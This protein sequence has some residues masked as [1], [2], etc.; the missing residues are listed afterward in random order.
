MRDLSPPRFMGQAREASVLGACLHLTRLFFFASYLYHP[1]PASSLLL[2]SNLA[3]SPSLPCVL[4]VTR[5]RETACSPLTFLQCVAKVEEFVPE[6]MWTA[7]SIVSPLGPSPIPG[8]ISSCRRQVWRWF[9]ELSSAF[10]ALSS[11][12]SGIRA[13][14]KATGVGGSCTKTISAKIEEWM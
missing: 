1:L 5:A 8:L 14:D 3:D 10:P 9:R 6:G 7:L 2:S 4:R 12:F 13:S 11:L